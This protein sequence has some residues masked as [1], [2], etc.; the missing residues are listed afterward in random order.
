[1]NHLESEEYLSRKAMAVAKI[2]NGI[3]NDLVLGDL[4]G[5]LTGTQK[6]L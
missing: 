6:I 3:Q 5:T 1:M 4:S 2:K